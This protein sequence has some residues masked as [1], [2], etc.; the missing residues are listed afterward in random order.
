MTKTTSMQWTHVECLEIGNNGNSLKLNIDSAYIERDSIE[1][2]KFLSILAVID[3][4][5]D[6]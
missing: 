5:I 1:S 4:P 2:M 3:Y 6:E